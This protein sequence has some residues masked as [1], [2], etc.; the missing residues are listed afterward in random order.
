MQSGV[1]PCAPAFRGNKSGLKNAR[2]LATLFDCPTRNVTAMVDCLRQVP[3]EAIT[4]YSKNP[5]D[6]TVS[7]PKIYFL[8]QPILSIRHFNYDNFPFIGIQ[9]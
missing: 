8:S 4:E 5:T 3:A 1:A 9:K 7:L 2:N 6:D